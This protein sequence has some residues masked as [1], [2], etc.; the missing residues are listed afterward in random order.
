MNELRYLWH[1]IAVPAL[2]FLAGFGV[3]RAQGW[4]EIVAV[5]LFLGAIAAQYWVWMSIERQGYAQGYK[6]ATRKQSQP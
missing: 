3:S 4:P 1:W 6:A 2:A 5:A